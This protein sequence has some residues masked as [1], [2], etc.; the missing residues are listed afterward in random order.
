[1][2]VKRSKSDHT[3]IRAQHRM[4]AANYRNIHNNSRAQGVQYKDRN[5]AMLVRGPKSS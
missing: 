2:L 3:H 4:A 1:M 5:P